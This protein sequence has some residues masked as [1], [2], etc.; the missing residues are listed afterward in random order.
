ML[1]CFMLLRTFV[2]CA[3]A[4][5]ISSCASQ[6]FAND[7]FEFFVTVDSPIVIPVEVFMPK[8]GVP[9]ALVVVV[10][11]SD[12]MADPYLLPDLLRPGYEPNVISNMT[13]ALL[14][15][16]YAVAYYSQRGLAPPKSCVVGSSY[17]Q[18]LQ[19]YSDKCVDVSIR[20]N[21]S[22][23]TI[24]SD[25][26]K[27]FSSLATHPRLS[28]LPQIAAALSEGLYHVAQLVQDKAIQPVGIISVG[29]PLESLADGMQYQN[30]HRYYFD[31]LDTAFAKCD[32]KTLR[33]EQTFSCAKI[34]PT[35][36]KIN[37]LTK[38]FDG[39]SISIGDLVKRKNYFENET[40]K[41]YKA[42]ST[43]P[44]NALITHSTGS[45]ITAI[46]SVRYYSE[47]FVAIQPISEKLRTFNG[48][49]IL[50]YGA[51]DHRARPQKPGK[52]GVSLQAQNAKNHCEIIVLA[53]LG[54][55]LENGSEFPAK[56]ALKALVTAINNVTPL[57]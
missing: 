31:L 18:R 11:G 4:C 24:T 14:Q 5:M 30:S 38:V 33:I 19:S 49:L 52:C 36:E 15:S 26:Q 55:A 28:K 22:L 7:R 2:L 46:W 8:N 29:G 13:N 20:A 40:Q 48:G 43:L 25:T 34:H 57:R 21:V 35:Q 23:S 53:G 37:A 16:N 17:E 41:F 50:L 3:C 9:L 32:T 51:E 42:H 45:R 47:I 1:V 27:I 6:Q 10:P 39:D 54:H 12:G 44:L 56:S